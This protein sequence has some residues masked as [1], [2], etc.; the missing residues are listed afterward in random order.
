MSAHI[1]SDVLGIST[2]YTLL[3]I[4]QLKL[5]RSQL[6]PRW[7]VSY[8]APW[9]STEVLS[10]TSMVSWITLLLLCPSMP[11]VL[12][13]LAR[14]PCPPAALSAKVPHTWQVFFQRPS[15][16][17]LPRGL[18]IPAWWLAWSIQRGYL[19]SSWWSLY[20][21]G[22]FSCLHVHQ[23]VPGPCGDQHSCR[24]TCS[25]NRQC[26]SLKKGNGLF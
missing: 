20:A 25:G 17:N 22:N 16:H 7:Q 6:V 1:F 13:S 18:L 2:S 9:F 21:E 26:P 10:D 15:L 11:N 3:Q 24:C 12:D 5:I 23:Q 14:D 19:A 4:T 8:F